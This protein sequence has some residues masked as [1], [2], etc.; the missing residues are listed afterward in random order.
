MKKCLLVLMTGMLTWMGSPAFAVEAIDG[1]YQINNAQDLVAFSTDIVATGAGSANAVLNADIDMTGVTF[2]PIGSTAVQYTGTFDGQC[3]YIHNLVINLPNNDNVGLFGAVSNGATIKNVIVDANSSVSGRAYVGGIVGGTLGTGSITLENVGN[4]AP[5]TA[6]AENAAGLVGVSSLGQCAIKLTNCFNTGTISGARES[7]SFCG[8]LGGGSVITNCYS[9]ADIESGID[10]NNAIYRNSAVI[11][12]TLYDKTAL[13]G[14]V[15]D[16]AT[17]LNGFFTYALNNQK[18]S[19]VNWYQNIDQGTLDIYPVPFK[20][21][22]TVYPNGALYCDGTSKDPAHLSFSNTNN[23]VQDP[24]QFTDGVCD[25]CGTVDNTY[26]QAAADGY[27]EIATPAQLYWFASTVNSGITTV[28]ARLLADI[29]Y[30]SKATR[31]GENSIN[32]FCGTFNGQGHRITINFNTAEDNLALFSFTNGATIKNLM[33]DGNITTSG[34]FSGGIASTTINGGVFKNVVSAVNIS[35]T[36]AGDVTMG[37]ITSNSAGA[38]RMKN[39]AFVG[40]INAPQSEGSAGLIGYAHGGNEIVIENSYVAAKMNLSLG[41]FINRKAVVLSNCHY[42]NMGSS[43]T[44]QDADA[45]KPASLQNDETLASGNLCFLLNENT[46]GGK[47]WFE[48][49]G[50]DTYPVPFATSG[51]VYLA[52]KTTCNTRP[53]AETTYSNQDGLIVKDNHQLNENGECTVCGDRFIATGAQLLALQNDQAAGLVQPGVTVELMNDIDMTG[54]SNY[55]GVGTRTNPF[56]GTFNGKGFRIKN[57]IIQTSNGNTGLFGL[58]SGGAKIK[59][60]TVDASCDIYGDAGWVG[61]IAGV[62]TNNGGLVSMEN[63]GNEA[64]VS[65]GGSNAAGIIGVVEGGLIHITNAYNAG[66]ITGQRESATISGWLSKNAVLTNVYNSGYLASGID[67]SHSFA[68]ISYETATLENCYETNGTQVITVND[69]QVQSG[70]LCYLLN[71]KVDNGTPFYQT[72]SV[73]KHPVFDITHY[74]VYKLGDTYFNGPVGTGITMPDAVK[75]TTSKG[76]Y[77]LNGVKMNKLQRGINIVKT[78]DGK[79]QK[80]LVQ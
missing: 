35:C 34:R 8:W 28:N 75:N 51:I 21:H 79:V 48:T 12:G 32:P 80:V 15:I 68:R 25:I 29:D 41:N 50:T 36:A 27:Y 49:F 76:I 13:Q 58:I 70:E 43:F 67:G 59:N 24:H 46:S 38:L 4:E 5:V 7:A 47:N 11:V 16:G 6:S 57:M 69:S 33:V 74:T 22:G 61:G 55:I 18:I 77:N 23:S 71:G 40:S 53:T 3:H 72:L 52:G 62:M 63:V 54:I 17:L 65:T 64:S 9:Y 19:S 42:L 2:T 20:T 39:V 44:V 45:D 30:T 60:V 31:I 56:V 66:T 1:V 73:D 10:G 14:K 78:E 26:M 37:G